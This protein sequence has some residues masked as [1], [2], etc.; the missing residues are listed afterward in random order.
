[1]SK[2]DDELSWSR[3][4]AATTPFSYPNLPNEINRL[5]EKASWKQSQAIINASLAI[6]EFE[7]KMLVKFE[8]LKWLGCGFLGVG[9][10]D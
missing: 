9:D 2:L 6:S 7:L 1:M 10:D 4:G 8:M 5:N 3:S